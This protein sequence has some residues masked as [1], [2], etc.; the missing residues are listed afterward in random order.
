MPQSTLAKLLK[1][2]QQI[3]KDI[4]ETK[5]WSSYIL[6]SAMMA[7]VGLFIFGVVMGTSQVG[8]YQHWF[9]TGWKVIVLVLAPIALCTP[10]LFVFSAIRGATIKLTELVYLLLGGLATSGIVLLALTPLTWFFT[11]TTTELNFIKAMNGFFIVIALI[12]GLF[13]FEQGMWHVYKAN[14]EKH[15]QSSP[16]I[17]IILFW[18]I[19]LIIVI[20]QMSYKLAPWY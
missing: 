6:Q 11:W 19:L 20:A 8:N 7:L 15:P 17:D 2:K 10:A 12:F 5:T 3:Y 18:F 14:K 13:F 16:A 9:T 4:F 1:N